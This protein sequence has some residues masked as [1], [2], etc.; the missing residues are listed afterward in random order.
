MWQQQ[1]TPLGGSLALSALAAAL[2]LFTLLYLLGVKRKASWVAALAGLGAAVLVALLVYRTPAAITLGALTYG[3]AFGL[4]PICWIIFWAIFLYRLSVETGQFEIIKDSIG[5]LTPDRRLQALL[6]AFAFGAFV[7]GA[8]GFGAPVAV[9]AAMLTGLGFS[10][11]YA[12]GICL[13]A[14]TAPVAFGSIGIPVITLAGITG[15]PVDQLSAAVGRICA[16]VSVWI[17]CYLILVMGGWKALKGVFAAALMVGVAFAGAQFYAS[18]YLGPELTDILGSLAAIAMA[19]LF[20][21]VFKP[22]DHFVFDGAAAEAQLSPRHGFRAVAKAWSPY[23]LLVVCVLLWGRA[24]VKAFLNTF[25]I[26]VEWP[27]LH[28]QVLQAPPVTL[29]AAPYAARYAFNWLSAAGTA[30]LLACF[31]TALVL[32]VPLQTLRLVFR[33]TCS[34]LAKPTLTVASVLALAFLM[35]YSG[36]TATLG[37]AFAATGAAFPFFSALLGWLGVFLT[38]SD[39]SANALF[40]NLQVVTSNKLGLN[41]ILMAA[42]NSSGGVMGKMISLQSIAVAAAAT[43]MSQEDESRLFRFTLRH[44]VLLA[45]VIGLVVLFY[46]YVRPD[47]APGA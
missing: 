27:G 5:G 15:L 13:L 7:E 45:S 31:L 19:L 18:N 14:N 41:P 21:Y 10:P 32:R 30:C 47:W 40:G 44:S 35:N 28:N 33:T 9:A 24:E 2:P 42:S 11:F 43:D 17:P 20:A 37:L 16:P 4:F 23:A 34:Q 8:A 36:A 38:G 12:A 3:A 25:T 22:A 26:P 46:A 1:Y 6:I 39:T 29:K